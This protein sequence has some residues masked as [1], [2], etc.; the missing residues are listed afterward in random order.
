MNKAITIFVLILI[1]RCFTFAQNDKF[2]EKSPVIYKVKRQITSKPNDSIHPILIMKI[3][4]NHN[5][6]KDIMSLSMGTYKNLKRRTSKYF[7]REVIF[8]SD[9]MFIK[10]NNLKDPVFVFK[11]QAIGDTLTTQKGHSIF[12]NHKINLEKIEFIKGINDE[13]Y[14]F[15]LERQSDNVVMNVKGEEIIK[16]TT[17]DYIYLQKIAISKKYGFVWINY[18]FLSYDI[19]LWFK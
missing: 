10:H 17:H 14:V 15:N 16:T 3:Y 19:E 8:Q 5:K 9:T 12:S 4:F 7:S 1:C 13:I 11:K 6:R 18:K 2:F